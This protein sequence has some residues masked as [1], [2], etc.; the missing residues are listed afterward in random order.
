MFFNQQRNMT[1]GENVVFIVRDDDVL[2]SRQTMCSAESAV[3][4]D[5]IGEFFSEMMM[6]FR[7]A[8]GS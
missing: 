6:L 3:N 5:A 4:V 8:G 7:V 2:R 1:S